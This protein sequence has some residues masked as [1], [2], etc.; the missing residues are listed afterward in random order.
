[1]ILTRPSNKGIEEQHNLRRYVL[2][3][4]VRLVLDRKKSGQDYS[5]VLEAAKKLLTAE[6]LSELRGQLG[7]QEI[8]DTQQMSAP[9]DGHQW[10]MLRG[11]GSRDP[12]KWQ[13]VPLA[14]PKPGSPYS[15]KAVGPGGE[16]QYGEAAMRL[17]QAKMRAMQS[18]A[19][20]Q[21]TGGA[22][23]ASRAAAGTAKPGAQKTARGHLTT[24][25]E[26]HAQHKIS[27]G[28]GK[29]FKPALDKKQVI[30]LV[31][32][33]HALEPHELEAIAKN[34]WAGG[35]KQSLEGENLLAKISRYI[36]GLAVGEGREPSDKPFSWARKK[37]A[38][39]AAP[40][41]PGAAAGPGRPLEESAGA[42]IQG[43]QKELED[44]IQKHF[45]PK[46]PEAAKPE[47]AVPQP[48]QQPGQSGKLESHE[49]LQSQ[50]QSSLRQTLQGKEYAH[51]P[52]ADRV[53]YMKAG[54]DVIKK[55]PERAL[56]S[57]IYN[58]K[59]K[60]RFY[61][62]MKEMSSKLAAQSPE[63][64]RVLAANPKKVVAVAFNKRTGELH[65]DGGN[66]KEAVGEVHA[67]AYTRAVDGPKMR[68]SGKPGFQEA[69]KEEGGKISTLASKSPQDGFAEFG[70]YVYGKG[71]SADQMRQIAPKS[72]AFWES[73]RLMPTAPKSAE[74]KPS[75]ADILIGKAE[76]VEGKGTTHIVGD[77]EWSALMP[78]GSATEISGQAAAQVA[79]KPEE[80][81]KQTPIVKFREEAKEIESKLPPVA[82]GHVRMWRGIRPSDDLSHPSG[83]A[84]TN[85]LPGIAMPF[86]KMYGGKLVYVDV[87][88]EN[89]AEYE[90]KGVTA[91]GAEFLIPTDVAKG[92]KSAQPEAPIY[93]EVKAEPE[94]APV[95][96]AGPPA[97]IPETPKETPESR[98]AKLRQKMAE[99]G[100]SAEA[101]PVAQAIKQPPVQ[102][103]SEEL[104]DSEPDLPLPDEP[105]SFRPGTEEKKRIIE[106]RLNAG[107]HPHHPGDAGFEHT[108][109]EEMEVRRKIDER[110]KAEKKIEEPSPIV[111]QEVVSPRE[112]YDEA[113]RQASQAKGED[114]VVHMRRLKDAGGVH[115]SDQAD[116]EF[117]KLAEA[118]LLHKW[119]YG[120]KI[121][122]KQS[123]E[124]KSFMEAD[125][126]F[127]RKQA[128]AALAKERPAEPAAAPPAVEPEA[129]QEPVAP[130]AEEPKKEEPQSGKI[131]LPDDLVFKVGD[132]VKVPALR[133][134][135]G[136][137]E[138]KIIKVHGDGTYYVEKPDG[139]RTVLDPLRYEDS[140]RVQKDDPSAA[141]AAETKTPVPGVKFVNK[142]GTYVWATTYKGKGIEY[143]YFPD[144]R[145]WIVRV[146][147]KAVDAGNTRQEAESWAR[148]AAEAIDEQAGDSDDGDKPI[149]SDAAHSDFAGF[150]EKARDI[151]DRA[152]DPG[153]TQEEIDAVLVPIKNLSRKKGN[154]RNMVAIAE[155]IYVDVDKR[156][157]SDE[158][159]SKIEQKIKDKLLAGQINEHKASSAAA[160]EPLKELGP[161]I[162]GVYDKAGDISIPIEEIE[163]SLEPMKF[164][165]KAELVSLASEHLELVG[166]KTKTKPQIIAAIRRRIIDRRIAAQRG[167]AAVAPARE[168]IVSEEPEPDEGK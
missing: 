133:A 165:T 146:D 24:I 60:I 18:G 37:A 58:T 130:V 161:K 67:H 46:T 8:P 121:H 64:A 29:P 142:P 148:K 62:S 31:N 51:I 116:K 145:R 99:K 53:A 126:E 59:G 15:F 86:Q 113:K 61:G 104:E 102:E 98:L 154:K 106:E 44:V 90:S 69:I 89:A 147:G 127:R 2:L 41:S 82:E 45:T 160:R 155:R 158:I 112:L 134:V 83:T 128:E 96:A 63:V 43:F 93:P 52:M 117:D 35:G 81:V 78:K 92:A 32:N 141:P 109:E 10:L 21:R 39:P 14:H 87:P 5:D 118:G 100:E 54:N 33:L 91:P 19:N 120:G 140:G 110:E 151:Y 77:D 105:T 137:Y 17:Y 135:H 111:A 103:K 74:L 76:P 139:N 6:G 123:P 70:R 143:E 152:S 156:D 97:A 153:L 27:G 107:R 13:F 42:D 50:A 75:K 38:G 7:D 66:L 94:V 4:I 36:G 124:G 20:V 131:T 16:E 49:E 55:M 163:K 166:M 164:L 73:E 9:P 149:V 138:A 47:P 168:L 23:Q 122:Y 22:G 72:T 159:Y 114:P 150:A 84:M 157:S 71:A 95:A 57:F 125:A 12:M 167:E 25:F 101:K 79:Q 85:D 132:S 80:P 28:Q 129:K 88:K 56:R 3:A 162:R 136:P 65:I 119:S 108:K 48:A 26:Q 40:P 34:P 68:F 30:E 11:A 144:H 115:M 1:M